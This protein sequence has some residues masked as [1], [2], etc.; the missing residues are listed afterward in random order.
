[1]GDVPPKYRAAVLLGIHYIPVITRFATRMWLRRH[2]FRKF[3]VALFGHHTT[4]GGFWRSAG[5]DIDRVD[6][7]P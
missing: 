3:A 4:H 7:Q 2:S 6:A 1:M 5:G